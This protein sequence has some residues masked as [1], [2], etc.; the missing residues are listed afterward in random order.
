MFNFSHRVPQRSPAEPGDAGSAS[1]SDNEPPPTPA[2]SLP[3]PLGLVPIGDVDR[4]LLTPAP[5]SRLRNQLTRALHLLGW[6]GEELDMLLDEA[7]QAAQQ[8]RTRGVGGEVQL[9]ASADGRQVQIWVRHSAHAP[10]VS[11]EVREA[12]ANYEWSGQPD[13]GEMV[14]V[15]EQTRP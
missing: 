3:A 5:G 12:G 8:A 1:A 4:V 6:G 13:A 11:T 7:E 10:E 14:R 2:L 9:R 15:I